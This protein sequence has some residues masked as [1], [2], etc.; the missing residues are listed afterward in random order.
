MIRSVIGWVGIASKPKLSSLK[1]YPICPPVVTSG[2]RTGV[3]SFCTNGFNYERDSEE[4]LES[5][6]E[7]FEELLEQDFVPE[8]IASEADVTLSNGVLNVHL[9]GH[10][11][12]VIN[13]QSPNRQIWL[14]SPVSGPYRYD[15]DS[16]SKSWVYRHSGE[17]LH[18][19]LELELSDILKNRCGFQTDCHLGGKQ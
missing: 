15:Y 1:R 10:G 18:Q 8:S 9:P 11:T 16:E 19:L 14:S 2:R 7:K 13:K 5:L 3:I 17:S 12:Y 6:C 4:T